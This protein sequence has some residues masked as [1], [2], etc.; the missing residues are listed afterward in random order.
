LGDIFAAAA[1]ACGRSEKLL[2]F[3]EN[4]KKSDAKN[5]FDS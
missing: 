3:G 5:A 1:A 2:A 4:G